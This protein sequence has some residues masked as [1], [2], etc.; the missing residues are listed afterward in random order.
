MNRRGFTLLEVMLAI[1][2]LMAL[3]GVMSQFTWSLGQG[4]QRALDRLDRQA[5]IDAIIDRI[6]L[7][8]DTGSA[9]AVGEPGFHGEATSLQMYLSQDRPDSSHAKGL[10]ARRAIDIQFDQ[11][12]HTVQLSG[13]AM[14]PLGDLR[15]RYHNGQQWQDSFDSI[16]EGGLPTAVLVEAW[17]H[18]GIMDASEADIPPDRRRVMTVVGAW[19]HTP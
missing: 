11:Q 3:L 6:S 8:L 1:T 12:Q 16:E 4:Q 13:G 9:S 17:L 2:I 18:E 7:A 10:G 14:L 19:R 15:L 5:A